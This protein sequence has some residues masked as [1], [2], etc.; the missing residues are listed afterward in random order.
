MKCPNCGNELEPGKVYCDHC[1]HEIQIV[2]DYDPLDEMLI[3]QEETEEKKPENSQA[4]EKPGPLSGN[5]RK[6]PREEKHVPLRFRYK[7]LIFLTALLVC[8]GAFILSYSVITSDNNY[9]YQLRKGRQYEKKGEYEKA[10]MYLR[11][12]QELQNEKN[13]GDTEVLRLLAEAYAK[14]GAKD[15]ALT[16]MKQAV[17]TEELASGDGPA[18]QELYLDF[19]ELLNET[20]Q[21]ELVGEVIEDCPYSDIRE[22]LLPYQIEKP[23]CDTPEGIYNYYLRLNLTA[24]YGSIYYTLDGSIPTG[25]STR[26]E[27]PIELMEEGEVLLCAV[28][29][30]KKGMISEPLVLAYKLD[31]P[32]A[33]TDADADE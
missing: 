5:D 16:Y 7:C 33:G 29:I 17:E 30:N 24:E 15:P 23:A 26:Y 14:I 4:L 8:G 28:A 9:S 32:A 19:M 10:I 1:G 11:R 25:E 13:G 21:T 20:G 6:K 27:S 22:T 3:G 12:A 2:P 18:L 31:F